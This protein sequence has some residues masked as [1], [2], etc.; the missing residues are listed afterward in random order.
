MCVIMIVDKVNGESNVTKANCDF[1]LISVAMKILNF[2]MGGISSK[3]I[4]S[5]ADIKVIF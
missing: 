2:H 1:V 4:S 5:G 3:L